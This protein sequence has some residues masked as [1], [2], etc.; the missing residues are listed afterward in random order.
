MSDKTMTHTNETEQVS[1]REVE[2]TTSGRVYAP[3]TDIY[4]A[5]DQLVLL[6]DMPG[7]DESTIDIRLDNGEL[8]IVGHVEDTTPEGYRPMWTEYQTGDYRRV[9]LLPDD[10]DADGI[11]ASV[12]NGVLKLTLPYAEDVKP[13]KIEVKAG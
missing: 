11:E 5:D 9:F 4:E 8:T 1:T 13:K 6:A 7:V 12:K 2:P 3:R 10:I